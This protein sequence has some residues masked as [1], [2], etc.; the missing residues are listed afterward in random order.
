M[1]KVQKQ[2]SGH[3]K[4]I[5]NSYLLNLNINNNG[6]LHSGTMVILIIL[7][8]DRKFLHVFGWQVLLQTIYNT[9][10]GSIQWKANQ[11]EKMKMISDKY[12]APLTKN[13]WKMVHHWQPIHQCFKMLISNHG[14]Y[15][16]TTG[17]EY[18]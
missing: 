11:L 1:R 8:K 9:Q 3:G 14:W 6:I 15:L 16:A 4:Q 13:E 12:F 17:M 7:R 18:S 10:H 5:T 2:S